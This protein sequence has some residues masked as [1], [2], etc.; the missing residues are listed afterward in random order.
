[1]P[2]RD[3]S[4]PIRTWAASSPSEASASLVV[5]VT[6]G[7]STDAGPGWA[8][9]SIGGAPAQVAGPSTCA[10][11]AAESLA[12]SRASTPAKLAEVTKRPS[13]GSGLFSDSIAQ[14]STASGW[15]PAISGGSWSRNDFPR[16]TGRSVRM[17]QPV[18]ERLTSSASR[19]RQP[20]FTRTGAPTFTRVLRRFSGPRYS[21]CTTSA[22]SAAGWTGRRTIIVVPER[23]SELRS[24]RA[25]CARIA[26]CRG[27]CAEF[28]SLSS[29]I[30]LA[31]AITSSHG[32]A[33]SAGLSAPTRSTNG[34]PSVTSS[35]RTSTSS[36][37]WISRERG[38]AAGGW[39][40]RCVAFGFAPPIGWML[41][42]LKASVAARPSTLSGS[43]RQLEA[44]ETCN[45]CAGRGR[46]P[47]ERA[48]SRP[49]GRAG[50]VRPGQPRRER[51]HGRGDPRRSI[52]G[53]RAGEAAHLRS[54]Q[55]RGLDRDR[56]RAERAE[57]EQ[58]RRA[59]QR[60]RDE[61][62]E[63]GDRPRGGADPQQRG[64]CRRGRDAVAADREPD[65][66]REQRGAERERS[67][68]GTREPREY[69]LIARHRAREH[70]FGDAVLERGGESV[71]GE[72][73]RDRVGPDRNQREAR[74][75]ADHGELARLRGERLAL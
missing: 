44:S 74:D 66:E 46:C 69:E 3:R 72:Q 21:E 45:Q 38:W 56:P 57:Q 50:Q 6:S 41:A 54:E 63:R 16:S 23:R 43:A 26:I 15:P 71:R 19:L 34:M 36:P 11:T 27:G 65:R 5:A 31:E 22:R 37:S 70:R 67:A 35:A 58:R 62:R 75:C 68:P 32:W 42:T 7:A 4:R 1:M 17:R 29:R 18:T 14:A 48:R 73:R 25:S 47:R 8:P 60:E 55:G 52:R 30:R 64:Q 20:S 59:R 61:H 53:D 2:P 40:I 51:V 33:R 28:G 12:C 10:A 13:A 24:V 39:V 49:H 9:A